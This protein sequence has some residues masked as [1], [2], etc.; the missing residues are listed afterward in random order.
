MFK[1]SLFIDSMVQLFH[2]VGVTMVLK[3]HVGFSQRFLQLR[4]LTRVLP[5]ES[6]HVLFLLVGSLGHVGQCICAIEILLLTGRFRCGTLSLLCRSLAISRHGTRLN[7]RSLPSNI[8]GCTF[9]GR[10]KWH[11]RVWP[12]KIYW[13]MA[14]ATVLATAFFSN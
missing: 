4:A 12:N 6:L 11:T 7:L 5:H 13:F 1:K 8:F 2:C 10:T 9:S 3:L 14:N